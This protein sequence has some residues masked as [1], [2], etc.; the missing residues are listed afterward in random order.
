MSKPSKKA[1]SAGSRPRP[2]LGGYAIAALD[3]ECKAVVDKHLSVDDSPT[4]FSKVADDDLK[5]IAS[6]LEKWEIHKRRAEF[7]DELLGSIAAGRTHDPASVCR[8]ILSHCDDPD[9]VRDCLELEPPDHVAVIRVLSRAGS[10]KLVFL[11][12]WKVTQRQIVLK[13]LLGSPESLAQQI[14]REMQSHPLSWEHANIIQTH[15]A[16]NSKNETFLIEEYIR[17]VLH[18]DWSSHGILEAA[19]LFNDICN[20]L[21]HLHE[22]AALV[23]GDIKP[24]NIARRNNK[25]LLLDFGIC[26]SKNDFR[27]E[28]TATGSLRTRAPE[29][30]CDQRYDFPDKADVW[31]LGAT[32]FKVLVGRYPLFKA[33]EKIPRVSKPGERAKV[34]EQLRQRVSQWD[35]WVDPSLLDE[36][37]VRPVMAALERDPIKRPTS[38]VLRESILD[39][40]PAFLRTYKDTT[41]FS[42]VEQIRQ[43]AKYLPKQRVLDML[44]TS[45]LEG[46]RAVVVQLEDARSLPVE[47]TA[48]L[49]EIKKLLGM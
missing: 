11:A 30:I 1:P 24:D 13:R 23:H 44:P 20:A 40:L 7:V 41:R 39:N 6:A 18:D 25:Y 33:G 38:A 2:P 46:L 3:E 47:T 22:Y 45:E 42:P 9:A 31:A 32:V 29:L 37:I 21:V 10:Q 26:R 36:P 43:L 14:Q 17:D 4:L 15:Y 16:T 49:E 5:Q 48:K 8:W 28:V 12:D 34:E 35:K 27:G 19:N